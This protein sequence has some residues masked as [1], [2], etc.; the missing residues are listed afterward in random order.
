MS[1]GLSHSLVHGK[2]LVKSSAGVREQ[3][4]ELFRRAS[5]E[6]LAR[7]PEEAHG[8]QPFFWQAD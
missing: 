3:L 2:D 8:L 7:E 6:H 5:L 1:L 4:G